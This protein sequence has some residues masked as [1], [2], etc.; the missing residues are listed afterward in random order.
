MKRTTIFRE[1]LAAEEILL[2]PGAHDA[3]T[4]KIIFQSGFKAYTAGGYAATAGMLGAP[5][6]SQL[7][8]T[9]MA[10]F[11]A[12][13]CD[14][15]PLPILADA[16]TGYGGPANVA[17][18]VRAYERAGVAALFIEDQVFPKRCGHMDGK[19]V[20]PRAEWLEKI[21]AALD[22]RMD[23]D[24][25]VMA[26]TDALAVIGIDEAIERAQEAREAGADLLFVEAP[27][28]VEQMKRICSELDGPALANNVETGKTPALTAA[29]LEAIGYAAVAYPV[30]ATYA[31]TA[32]VRELMQVLKKEGTTRGMAGRM[33]TF[34][35][36]NNTVGLAEI[37]ARETACADFA[38]S[39]VRKAK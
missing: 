31:I 23:P 9:E 18:T 21:K 13:L 1:L 17:R 20:V 14:A 22:S 7:S 15:S 8:M 2:L 37:R 38:R 6:I 25:V 16:D 26:R 39:I 29:E 12:R 24:L 28:S 35:E 32:A 36:F 27:T 5:D 19:R 11:Y 33:V 3:L 34:E 10:D 4:A 30:A